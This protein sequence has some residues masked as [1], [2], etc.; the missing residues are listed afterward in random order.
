MSAARMFTSRVGGSSQRSGDVLPAS[1][2]VV[3][4]RLGVTQH[5]FARPRL[6]RLSH[7]AG[8]SRRRRDIFGAAEPSIESLGIGFERKKYVFAGFPLAA[9]TWRI[10]S[11]VS[12]S[13]K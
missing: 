2:N 9:A 10:I 3:E 7:C 11:V 13:R 1:R 12:P 6:F 4:L 5:P 8:R